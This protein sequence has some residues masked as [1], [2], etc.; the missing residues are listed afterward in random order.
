MRASLC[1]I[2]HWAFFLSISKIRQTC[3]IWLGTL[4]IVH[5]HFQK[6]C[7]HISAGNYTVSIKSSNFSGLNRNT[8]RVKRLKRMSKKLMPG[9]GAS[10]FC[11]VYV[12]RKFPTNLVSWPWR[13]WIKFLRVIKLMQ[14][15][16]RTKAKQQMSRK[17]KLL[18]RSAGAFCGRAT[19][20]SPLLISVALPFPSEQ[21]PAPDERDPKHQRSNS[22][23]WAPC[24][25]PRAVFRRVF[26]YAKY[27]TR[28]APSHWA[29]R[30]ASHLGPMPQITRPIIPVLLPCVEF[31][32]SPRI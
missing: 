16:W 8:E 26:M 2:T 18:R 19:K 31:P 22:L 4:I 7:I 23:L 32:A 10:R 25:L 9:Q 6:T 12:A 14:R 24:R 13:E 15:K 5:L 20:A 30:S 17:I 29:M 11:Y 27:G 1:K 28:P 21:S 3:I